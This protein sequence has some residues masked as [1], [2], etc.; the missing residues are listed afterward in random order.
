MAIELPENIWFVRSNGGSGS[1]P[2]KPQGWR[3]VGIFVAGLVLSGILT[4]LALS[5]YGG[6]AFVIF[7][8]G[9]IASA[10]YFIATARAHTDFTI[11]YNDYV[12]AKNSA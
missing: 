9:A 7:V 2:V 3:V 6:W 8:A 4:A 11:T 5:A 10:W 1:Y 12:K